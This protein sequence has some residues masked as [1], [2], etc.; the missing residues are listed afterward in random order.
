MCSPAPQQ[1]GRKSDMHGQMANVPMTSN[2]IAH[3]EVAGGEG[4]QER[5]AVVDK[6]GKGDKWQGQEE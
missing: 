1:A 2:F 5:K 4:E 6:V 3:T